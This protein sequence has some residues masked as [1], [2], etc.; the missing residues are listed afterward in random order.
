MASPFR[1]LHIKKYPKFVNENLLESGKIWKKLRNQKYI[2]ETASV[3]SIHFSPVAPYDFAVTSSTRVQIYSK[4]T[5]QVKKS[6]A[7]FNDVAYS[8]TIRNDGKLLVAGDA[9]GCIQLFDINSRAILRTIKDHK[10]PVQVAKFSLGNSTQILSCSD[11]K[12][13]RLW[14]VPSQVALSVFSDHKDY[15]RAGTTSINNPHLIASGSYDQ[16]IKLWDTRSNQCEITMQHGAPVESLLIFPSGGILVSAGGSTLQVWDLIGGGRLVHSLSNHQKTIT[17]LC[18]DSSYSHILTGSLDRHIKIYDVQDYKVIHSFKYNHPILSVAFS[19]DDTCLVTG[20]TS[21]QMAIQ[22]RKSRSKDTAMALN[23]KQEERKLFGGTW[24]FFKRGQNYD[25]IE[26]DVRVEGTR[27]KKLAKYDQYL[28]GFRY[29]NALDAALA[30][31]NQTIIGIAMI[32]ELIHRDGLRQALAN[33]N[34]DSLIPIIRFMMRNIT[35]LMYRNLLI[36]V[37]EILLDL[38][39]G[40]FGHKPSPVIEEFR[41]LVRKV[42]DEIRIQK[43]CLKILGSLRMVISSADRVH[44]VSTISEKETRLEASVIPGV[45]TS[46][47][48]DMNNDEA[49]CKVPARISS[50]YYYE[51]RISCLEVILSSF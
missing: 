44:S 4:K 50:A 8:G 6:I 29:S 36:D 38:Y 35:I 17:S 13:V 7:R 12:T 43:E 26:E 28:R 21:G 15:V 5:H 18:F 19:P 11:D 41:K 1:P 22:Q 34:E 49:S 33:R 20:M 25:G 40:S 42:A 37:G 27:E 2:D 9:T 46:L 48:T 10:L 31:G 3:T 16:T 39:S 32:I 23:K 30:P 24:E 47:K 14:D 45:E 51:E